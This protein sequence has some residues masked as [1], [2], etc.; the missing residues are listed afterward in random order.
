MTKADWL[1]IRYGYFRLDGTMGI[2]K[3]SK[4]V[5]QFNDPEGS[6]FVFLLS[7]KAGGCG[8]NLIGA[9]RL[10]LF[11]PGEL[12]TTTKYASAN[13]TF[14]RLEPS[15]GSASTCAYLA[16]WPK[17]RMFVHHLDSLFHTLNEPLLPCV[18]F[19]YRLITTGTIEEKILQRQA[20]KQALS[21]SV[22]DQ[23]ENTELHFS[24]QDLRKLFLFKDNT[25]CETHDTFKCKRCKNGRQTIK[26]PALLYGDAST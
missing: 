11:D 19:V 23:L 2:T 17:E 16:W 21:A 5:D 22:V 4:I 7:S 18:G 10:V 20:Q 13:Q 9:N 12:K 1:Y 24:M 15:V 14:T 8:I 25:V 3:R 26:S 6:E